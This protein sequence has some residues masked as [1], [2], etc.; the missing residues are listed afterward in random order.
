MILYFRLK[1]SEMDD[2]RRSPSI[3]RQ[4]KLRIYL[5][6]NRRECLFIRIDGF[7]HGWFGER[8]LK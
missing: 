2:R 5:V 3:L 1:T 8:V 6:R 4:D 7:P